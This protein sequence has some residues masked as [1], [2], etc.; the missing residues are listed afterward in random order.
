VIQILGYNLRKKMN[1]AREETPKIEEIYPRMDGPA[2]TNERP[3]RI[4][5]FASGHAPT[6]ARSSKG[7]SAAP[8]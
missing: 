6:A 8:D 1:L 2:T 3:S 7:G 5:A 4:A